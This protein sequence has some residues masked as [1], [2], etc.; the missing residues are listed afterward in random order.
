MAQIVLHFILFS[1]AVVHLPLN[2]MS[3]PHY[4]YMCVSMSLCILYVWVFYCRYLVMYIYAY[5]LYIQICIY[6]YIYT[7]VDGSIIV[8]LVIKAHFV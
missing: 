1:Q 8:A 6:I 3:P 5:F 7:K 4:T 2:F